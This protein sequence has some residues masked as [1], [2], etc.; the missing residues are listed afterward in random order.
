MKKQNGFSIVE[1]LIIIVIIGVVGG[2]GWYVWSQQESDESAKNN[3][4]T[5]TVSNTSFVPDVDIAQIA[6]AV[7]S[8]FDGAEV[9]VEEDSQILVYSDSIN[10]LV[11]VK[12]SFSWAA[13]ITYET[14]VSINEPGWRIDEGTLS[15]YSSLIDRFSASGLNDADEK[16]STVYDV[17]NPR[18]THFDDESVLCTV[19]LNSRE[20]RI[21]CISKDSINEQAL[22]IKPFYDAYTIARGIDASS[23]ELAIGIDFDSITTNPKYSEFETVD[24]GLNYVGSGAYT[25]FYRQDQGSWTFGYSAQAAPNCSV[26]NNESMRKAYYDRNCFGD[27]YTTVGEF[28]DL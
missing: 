2:A 20:V 3:I 12:N 11:G 18:M 4:V 15:L 23:D 1:V 8:N 26:F 14:G 5:D 17:S 22:A 21:N 7:A 28:Y 19:T 24:G 13:T 25:T 16:Y 10:R 27:D 9:Q 6:N